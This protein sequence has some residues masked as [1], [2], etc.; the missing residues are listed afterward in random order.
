MRMHAAVLSGF[1]SPLEVREVDLA[2]PGPGEVRVR[3]RASGICG[4]DAK[5]AAGLNPLYPE[6]GVVLGHESVGVVAEVG[7]GV[8]S[9]AVGDAVVIAMN[10]WCG[11]CRECARGRAYLCTGAARQNAIRGLL[12]DGTSR[13]SLDGAP[14]LPFVGIGSFAEYTVV[15]ESML[16][17]LGDVPIR[18][19]LA[20]VACGVVTGVGAV[21]NVAGVAPGDTVLVVGCG[22]V[23]LA[24]VAGAALAGA[25][26]IVAADTVASKLDLA[27]AMGATDV[28][29]AGDDLAERVADVVPGGVDHA[30]DVTGAP[31]VLARTMA[32]TRPGGTTVLVGSPAAAVEIPPVLFFG[33]RTV[34]GCVGGNAVPA[35]DLPRLVDL[36]ATGRLDLSPLVSETVGLAEVDAALARQK[37]GEVA[38]SVIVF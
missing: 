24:A 13:L 25:S 6:P 5:V 10:R 22:G 37:A 17:R 38:R 20:L 15:G 3:I 28:V 21:R 35:D 23:G 11:R 8:D 19:E 14:L 29:R 27:V 7:Q 2:P 34:R 4:S 12:A 26:R 16:V 36:V 9:V 18:P 1:G 31:G 32:A 30:F 33:G